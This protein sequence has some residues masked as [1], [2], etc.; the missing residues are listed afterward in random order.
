[1]REK[2]VW[3]DAALDKLNALVKV[4]FGD[5]R[6]RINL[7]PGDIKERHRLARLGP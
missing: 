5:I 4:K 2:T 6:E 1:M 3:T 7:L